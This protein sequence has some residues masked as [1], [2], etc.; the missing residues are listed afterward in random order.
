MKMRP[1]HWDSPFFRQLLFDVFFSVSV[2]GILVFFCASSYQLLLKKVIVLSHVLAVFDSRVDVMEDL[3]VIGV[4]KDRE[5]PSFKYGPSIHA[6]FSEGAFHVGLDGHLF[7]GYFDELQENTVSL[8][9]VT[10]ENDVLGPLIWV[11]GS[12]TRQ[13]VHGAK[14]GNLAEKYILRDLK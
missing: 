5:V 2:I 7:E 1:D 13:E 11:A 14:R 10:P 8:R 12:S 3:A 6:S 4:W 9:A